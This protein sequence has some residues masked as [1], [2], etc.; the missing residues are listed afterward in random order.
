MLMI[1]KEKE[2]LK[3]VMLSSYD[4][5]ERHR[6]RLHLDA[7]EEALKG[8]NELIQRYETE[9]NKDE[10][11]QS[12]SIFCT[13]L[14]MLVPVVALPRNY[15]S[16]TRH[17]EDLSMIKSLEKNLADCTKSNDDKAAH[18]RQ[19][20]EVMKESMKISEV[21]I[22]VIINLLSYYLIACFE[23]IYL[24]ILNCTGISQ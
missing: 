1:M 18:L 13:Y 16:T 3:T 7:I 22:C 10:E 15:R 14:Y 11:D 8:T 6:V 17:L 12:E 24:F 19:Q 21:R 23:V 9:M 5:D 20:I 4:N 2:R